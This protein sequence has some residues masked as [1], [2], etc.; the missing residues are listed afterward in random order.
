MD[1]LFCLCC[2]SLALRKTKKIEEQLRK[3]KITQN[4]PILKFTNKIQKTC[5][6]IKEKKFTDKEYF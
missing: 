5:Q 6:L 4:D 1:K 3:A 2:S